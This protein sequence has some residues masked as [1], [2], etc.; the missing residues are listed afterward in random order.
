MHRIARS[1]LAELALINGTPGL[2]VAPGGRLLFALTFTIEG[3]KITQ[4]A[5]IADP[6]RLGQL[7]LAVLE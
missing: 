7:T 3:D 5:A 2:I 4:Y 1:R 6:E